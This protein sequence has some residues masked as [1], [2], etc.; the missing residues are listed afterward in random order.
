M[1]FL[2]VELEKLRELLGTLPARQMLP[3]GQVRPTRRAL[4]RVLKT[5]DASAV[6]PKDRLQ[7]TRRAIVVAQ[8]AADGLAALPPR[9]L[10]DAVWLLWPEAN[11][12]VDRTELHDAVKR[13]LGRDGVLL[14]RLIDA[15][16]VGFDASDDTFVGFGRQIDR[17]LAANHMGLLALWKEVHQAY[18]LFDGVNG[19]ERLATRLLDDSSGKQ[20]E[21]CRLDTPA[22]AAS[23]Y[24]RAVHLAMS[25]K[26]PGRLQRDRAFEIFERAIRFYAPEDRLRFDEPEPNGAMVDGLVGAWFRPGRLPSDRLRTEVLSFLRQ[27]LGDPRTDHARRW[28]SASEKAR[29]KVRSWLSAMT[30]DAFFDVLGRFAGNAGMGQQWAARKA[31]W[32][33]LLKAGYISDS[34]LILGENIARAMSDNAELRGSYGRLDD[35]TAPNQS[36]LLI[37]IGDLTFS[38]WTYVGKLRAWRNDWA[39]APKLFQSRYR[40]GDVAK[41]GIQFPP[42][43]GKEKLGSSSPDGIS[44]I[45]GV[46]QGRAAALLR[47]REGIVLNPNEWRV[48]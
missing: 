17:N 8:R 23:G 27:H 44:H 39:Q 13:R 3:S 24:L 48:R 31:F 47:A 42:P 33:A 15:W 4:E 11:D 6:P 36:V 20:L 9:L 12:G 37:R 10:R 14:R 25:E 18:E 38:E 19:P 26:L 35:A 30:L 7:A 40:R 21:A 41:E 46:W 29:Q 22:R 45:N 5:L 32:G 28:N 2:G 16:L 34:W 43:Q 1:S